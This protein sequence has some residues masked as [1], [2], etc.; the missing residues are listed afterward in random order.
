MHGWVRR[1]R[2]ESAE[3]GRNLVGVP[4]MRST[5]GRISRVASQILSKPPRVASSRPTSPQICPKLGHIISRSRPRRGRSNLWVDVDWSRLGTDPF[6]AN[7]DQNWNRFGHFGA[8]STD[9]ASHAWDNLVGGTT[10]FLKTRMMDAVWSISIPPLAIWQEPSSPSP[11]VHAR[12][13]P[14]P[15]C[16]CRRPA[17]QIPRTARRCLPGCP[18]R[19]SSSVC[20]PTG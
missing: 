11:G 12:L 7:F 6:E 14:R 19:S 13:S 18:P 17:Q 15:S 9:P 2:S 1:H 20:C 10:G 3:L 16:A 5:P 4:P 8:M